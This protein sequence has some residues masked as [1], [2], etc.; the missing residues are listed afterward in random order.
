MEGLTVKK[1]KRSCI[2]WKQLM[3]MGKFLDVKQPLYCICELDVPDFP[4]GWQS[5]SLKPFENSLF[6]LGDHRQLGVLA[7]IYPEITFSHS[8]WPRCC[9]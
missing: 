5:D 7:Q 1:I 4:F 6:W 3:D 2:K 8:P 9:P